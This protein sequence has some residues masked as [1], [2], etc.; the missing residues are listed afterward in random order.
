MRNFHRDP[1]QNFD[2]P[3]ADSERL[4]NVAGDQL[5]LLHEQV[6]AVNSLNLQDRHAKKPPSKTFAAA[7]AKE[8][9][10]RSFSMPFPAIE[11]SADRS[12]LF[13]PIRG[14]VGKLQAPRAFAGR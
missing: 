9:S 5:R 1:A 11:G 13:L 7:L 3:R 12:L 4:V 14:R 8:N 6:S 10:A 2:P